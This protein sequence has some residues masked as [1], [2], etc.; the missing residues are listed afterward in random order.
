MADNVV[1]TPVEC[2]SYALTYES[3]HHTQ[4]DGSVWGF[5]LAYFY[6]LPQIK[7]LNG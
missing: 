3:V 7:G 2:A 5:Y 6:Y 1:Y 4:H